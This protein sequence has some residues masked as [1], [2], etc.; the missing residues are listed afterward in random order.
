MTDPLLLAATDILGSLQQCHRIA[1]VRVWF[2][3]HPDRAP[4]GQDLEDCLGAA[5][6]Q[7]GFSASDGGSMDQ[8]FM[9]YTDLQYWFDREAER[10]R[11]G[12]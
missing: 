5:G 9:S 4:V 8:Q 2:A 3:L 11:G 6:F 12:P 10:A 7:H 1:M